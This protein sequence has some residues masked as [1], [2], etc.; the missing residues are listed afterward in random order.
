MRSINLEAKIK[1]TQVVRR[2]GQCGGMESY[3][4]HLT[5]ALDELG[6]KVA[7]L[8]EEICNDP[9]KSVDIVCLNKPLIKPSWLSLLLFSRE[10]GRFYKKNNRELGL[11]HSHERTA[12][13]DITTFHGPPF[14]R[15]YDYP[16]YRLL[17]VRTQ[18]YLFMER[19]E[20]LGAQVQCVVPNSGL[21]RDSL[22]KYY[23]LV[24][25]R[26]VS[27]I[28]PGTG[29]ISVRP[30][31]VVPSKGG[32]IGFIGKEWKRKGLDLVIQICKN[33]LIRRPDLQLLILGPQEFEIATLL[34]DYP[35]KVVALGWAQSSLVF[36]EM[37]LLLH[38]AR[39]EPYGMVVA[40]AM[41]ARV[42]V[43]I[44]DQCGAKESVNSEVGSV[45]GINQPLNEWAKVVEVWLTNTQEIKTISRNWKTVALEQIELY[46]NLT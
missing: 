46:K 16:S 18:A 29:D 39:E 23:P 9:P 42:P 37:D 8:C 5:R 28:L 3:V 19:R 34:R 4:F 10:V 21:I 45:M 13:H 20:L 1:I 35:G 22:S 27:P 24:S 26:L 7:V 2:F 11:V 17:S 33:V 15:I 44:S 12:I 38:P 30:H 43:V 32:T 40:E 14:A 41:A 36:A 6:V 31:R 25:N